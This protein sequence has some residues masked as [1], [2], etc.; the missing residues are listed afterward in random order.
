MPTRFAIVAMLGFCLL[1]AGALAALTSRDPRRRKTI[2]AVV[3]AGLVIELLPIPRTLYSAS[4]PRIYDI[5][6]ADPRPVRVLEL[7]Y[8]V[9]DGLSS[10]GDFSAASQFHQTYHGKSIAGGYLSRVSAQRKASY[11]Q[12]AVRSALITLSERR[13]LLPDQERRARVAAENFLRS[14]NIGYVVIDM[15]RTS[16]ELRAFAI[17][18]L[19]LTRIAESD[20]FELFV[21]QGRNRP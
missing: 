4:V 1:F 5:I 15:G 10:L 13:P 6:A 2:L 14:R 19:G 12:L 17:Q 18:A 8:G 7:P 11:R 21:P 9:R 16:A 20:G 3:G